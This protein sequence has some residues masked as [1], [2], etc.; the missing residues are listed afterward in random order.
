MNI[1]RNMKLIT[2][3][4]LVGAVITGCEADNVE[5][6]PTVVS[7]EQDKK[8]NAGSSLETNIAS[9]ATNSTADLDIIKNKLQMVLGMGITSIGESPVA[10]LL[11]VMTD[12]GLF[13]VSADGGYFL[14]AKIYN[15]NKEMRNETELALSGARLDGLKTFKDDVIEYKAKNE[16]YVVSV[17]TDITC[18]YCRKLHNEMQDYNDLGITVRY[19]AFPRAG[20]PSDSYKDMVSVWCAENP[21]EAMT[22]AKN[23]E[24]ITDNSC[25]T[26]IAQ[27]YAFGQKVGVNGT[28]NIIL[29]DGSTIPGYQPPKQLEQALKAL[30]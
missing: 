6:S 28:P 15:L 8:I 14:Q 25:T 18:G 16:K 4:V 3:V 22:G 13:Y 23:G 24:Y 9:V 27:Q 30:M 7:V 21:Q 11:Q 29:P 10:G 19:L 2:L 17:F 1:V 12:R 26:S 20:V 5:A